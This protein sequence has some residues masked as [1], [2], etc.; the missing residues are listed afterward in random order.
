LTDRPQGTGD[1]YTGGRGGPTTYDANSDGT[2]T[3]TY[4]DANRPPDPRVG[5]APLA[6]P[7]SYW[8]VGPDAAV[9][10]K[11]TQ[12]TQRDLQLNLSAEGQ[13]VPVVFGAARVGPQFVYIKASSDGVDLWMVGG[14]CMGPIKS[15]IPNEDDLPLIYDPGAD[16]WRGSESSSYQN[17][18]VKVYDGTQSIVDPKL[19]AFDPSWNQT[20]GPTTDGKVGLA[21][22]RMHLIFDP[23]KLSSIPTFTFDIAGLKLY[24]PR[25]DPFY[26]TPPGT[27]A[28]DPT[29][30]AYI[31]YTENP[32]LA[33]R[34]V[35]VNTTWGR[36]LPQVR[37]DDASFILAANRCEVQ[38]GTAPNTV[39]R[40]RLCL[41]M[42]QQSSVDNWLRTLM[43][44]CMGILQVIN[45]K[46][47][48]V[49]DEPWTGPTPKIYSDA[50]YQI[51]GDTTWYP[52][53][54][55]PQSLVIAR[56]GHDSTYNQVR[57]TY[58]QQFDTIPDAWDPTK[59]Y[60]AGDYVEYNGDRYMS[61]MNN[62][63]NHTPTASTT[64][65][66]S[67][68]TN[69]PVFTQAEVTAQTPAVSAGTALPVRAEL[70]L[71][72]SPT[73]D[74]S[75][76][77]ATQYINRAW[78][79]L[80]VE[81]LAPREAVT[82]VPWDVIHVTAGG[83][84]QD[85]RVKSM[86]MVGSDFKM[87]CEE[88]HVES[89]NDQKADDDDEVVNTTLPDPSA[90]PAPPDPTKIDLA[91]QQVIGPNSEIVRNLR[92][93]WER[94]HDPFYAFTRIWV[95]DGVQRLVGDFVEGPIYIPNLAQNE[96]VTVTMKTIT[97]FGRESTISE[98]NI[99]P[100][101]PPV[102]EV[103]I[104]EGVPPVWDVE[105][106]GLI[107]W[108]NPP[109][110]IDH[111]E[112]YDVFGLVDP[113]T[114]P[115]QRI[116]SVKFAESPTLA[117]P[118][119]LRAWVHGDGYLTGQGFDVKVI[120]VT[121]DGSMSHGVRFQFT[122]PANGEAEYQLLG[123]ADPRD[124]DFDDLGQ[125]WLPQYG[126]DTIQRLTAA[127]NAVF[128]VSGVQVGSKPFGVA[129][130]GY[131][132]AW[133]G[134][135]GSFDTAAAYASGTAYNVNDV[136]VDGG[137][138]YTCIQAGTGHQ[139]ATN[140]AYWTPVPGLYRIDA[141]SGIITATVTNSVL[142][143]ALGVISDDANPFGR[144]I[145]VTTFTRNG[146]G[147][148]CR[149]A[150]TPIPTLTHALSTTDVKA[151]GFSVIFG[152]YL[153]TTCYYN[154]AIA[155]LPIYVDPDE[156]DSGDIALLKLPLT[157]RRSSNPWGLC[158][159]PA[160]YALP[161]GTD[162][163]DGKF[164]GARGATTQSPPTR[165]SALWIACYSTDQVIC[166]DPFTGGLYG[167]VELGGGAGPVDCAYDG[168][169]IWVTESQTRHITRIDPNTAA[170]IAR[171]PLASF[172]R[173]ILYD[174]SDLWVPMNTNGL[175]GSIVIGA[176]N[177]GGFDSPSTVDLMI[178]GTTRSPLP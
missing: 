41:A 23:T 31:A 159:G 24:D 25:L 98:A 13:F 79:D 121:P 175:D 163:I 117:S 115:G 87:S 11:R 82:T 116:A 59:V 169:S 61:R 138:A 95:D 49:I 12:K 86:Q 2:R 57:V 165:N 158:V 97:T 29:N 134:C 125:Y 22:A 74:Q 105:V 7:P 40:Y 132:Q 144:A 47:S 145:W 167:K 16:E 71:D 34:E 83:L 108:D 44:H 156:L 76:R 133:V 15:I 62:N 176:E 26:A 54:V 140:P 28:P 150:N 45:G 42:A 37:M 155:R 135:Y 107:W 8:I 171:I 131:N 33:I 84:D 126:N 143:G 75:Q 56:R 32:A 94:S 154:D 72:G 137:S 92:V 38:I 106:R 147:Y 174:G 151:F 112:V 149:I 118:L 122:V 89:Y 172:P 170:I 111:F 139:P 164:I 5:R 152:G 168:N 6:A 68:T 51:T 81:F 50:D 88:Y 110:L 9:A 3:V 142:A 36:A 46:Y 178:T 100:A 114:Q 30:P 127:T 39:P 91:W 104:P 141:Y 130:D 80:T 120:V 18:N 48:L 153:F 136:V 160:P 123:G 162:P 113:E 177:P 53:N 14:L 60:N 85:F 99:A 20:F 21:F 10:T 102:A 17:L 63:L 43:A 27:T 173:S 90:D 101:I 93:D 119:N 67:L 55:Q 148:I 1:P 166:I 66:W 64:G 128:S 65:W 109:I 69:R 103:I 52:A 70:T 19:A 35:L 58:T 124:V 4:T 146:V 96:I 77:L 157:S 129:V 73:K 78:D 161:V